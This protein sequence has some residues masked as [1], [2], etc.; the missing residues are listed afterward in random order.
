MTL[1]CI[2]TYNDL[3]IKTENNAEYVIE[4]RTYLGTTV[5]KDTI[6][7]INKT[8]TVKGLN[9]GKYIIHISNDNKIIEQQIKV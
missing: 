9:A 3:T 4:I 6:I 7:P 8:I 5:F 1:K 2:I